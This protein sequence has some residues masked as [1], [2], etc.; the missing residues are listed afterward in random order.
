MQMTAR[1]PEDDG[2]PGPKG[3]AVP[4]SMDGISFAI[5]GKPILSDVSLTVRP[6]EIVCLLGPSGCGK[7]TLLRIAA[8]IE[9][10]DQGSVV[11]GGHVVADARHFV[12]AEARK[13]GLVF[14][15]LALFPHM[16][17]A[18]NVTYG[19]NKLPRSEAARRA[20][21][22]LSQVGLAGYERAYPHELSGGQQQRVALVRALLPA[23]SVVLFDEPFSGLDRGLRATVREDTL[24]L[25]REREATAVMV[26][27]DPEE[28]LAV[29]DRIALMRAGRIV[30][31]ATPEEIWRWPVDLEAAKVFS[32]L[33]IFRGRAGGG[34]LVTPIGRVPVGPNREGEA[35]TVAFRP[36]AI[37]VFPMDRDVGVPAKVVRR[38]F[39]GTH[40]E[41]T[42]IVDDMALLLRAEPY[43]V[44]QADGVRVQADF[45]QAIVFDGE[46]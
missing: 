12:P 24:A 5:A 31:T 7:T 6:R 29:A 2:E 3:E 20:S 40:M 9:R 14:Q 23:P 32:S 25:L 21:E 34:M 17:I 36:D 38:R 19:V 1:R 43:L 16:R 4:L 13:L 8:G 18:E 15:D 10:Q 28:A 30:Q 26:T 41:L 27:H 11:V 45:R 22:A 42:V 46:Q 37:R 35:V 39:F 33:N 44:P